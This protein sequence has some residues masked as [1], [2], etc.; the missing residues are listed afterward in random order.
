MRKTYKA[1]PKSKVFSSI[2]S[3]TRSSELEQILSSGKFKQLDTDISASEDEIFNKS[4]IQDLQISLSK[5]SNDVYLIFSRIHDPND[6]PHF[7]Q[8]SKSAWSVVESIY[9]NLPA[10][11]KSAFTGRKRVYQDGGRGMLW[12]NVYM[13]LDPDWIK[14]ASGMSMREFIGLFY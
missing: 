2:Q 12:Y 10:E 9:N 3:R 4:L 14:S 11:S 5:A 1:I 6:Y 7:V 13:A 8:D